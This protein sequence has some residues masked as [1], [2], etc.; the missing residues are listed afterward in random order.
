MAQASYITLFHDLIAFKDHVGLTQLTLNTEGFK[1][2]K[3]RTQ[4]VSE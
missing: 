3:N 2:L 4:K 1:F